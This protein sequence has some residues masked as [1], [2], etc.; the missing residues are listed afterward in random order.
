M[1]DACF[2]VIWNDDFRRSTDEFQ[3]TDMRVDPARQIL[4]SAGFG[5]GVTAGAQ[6]GDKQRGLEIHLAGLPV[7]D[8]YPVSGIINEELFSGAVF[9]P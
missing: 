2:G 5:K 7:I 6:N 9:V 4:A 8:G 1:L 3:G